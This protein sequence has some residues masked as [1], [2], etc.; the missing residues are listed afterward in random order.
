LHAHRRR[1]GNR[2]RI[3]HAVSNDS[4]SAFLLS[5]QHGHATCRRGA[6]PERSRG[7]WEE[8]QAPWIHE[9]PRDWNDADAHDFRG[10]EFEGL[11]WY[12]QWFKSSWS[13]WDIAIEGNCLLGRAYK[14]NG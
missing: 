10:V 5:D 12:R 2:L 13:D 4:Q 14:L 8:R 1:S 9:L 7:A 11:G 3:E 6:C